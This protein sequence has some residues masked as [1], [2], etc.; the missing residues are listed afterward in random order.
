VS[1]VTS[2]I[3]HHTSPIGFSESAAKARAEALRLELERGLSPIDDLQELIEE[4]T[5]VDVAIMN[6]PEGMDGMVVTDPLRGRTIVGVATSRVPE[7]QRFTLAHELGHILFEDY[8]QHVHPDCT[9]RTPSEKRADNF[10]RH[11]LAPSSGVT[12]YLQERKVGRG[13]ATQRDV[14]FVVRHFGVS[15]MVAMIQMRDEG[16]ITEAQ[17]NLWKDDSA[18]KLANR[19]GWAEE[20]H[21]EQAATETPRPPQRMVENATNGYIK[22]IISLRNLARHRQM[23]ADELAKSL[24]ESN[25]YPEEIE[26]QW[27]DIDDLLTDND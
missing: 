8:V 3:P 12:K 13:E 18:L 22:N 7:R 21:A 19:Y 17:R 24:S 14:A 2:E 5:G 1:S 16:W 27:A 26:T 20:Y 25:L 10:A 23:N 6:M 11:L 4:Y 15:P 9:V